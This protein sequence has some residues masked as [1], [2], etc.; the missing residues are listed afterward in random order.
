M[1]YIK[2]LLRELVESLLWGMGRKIWELELIVL[3][4]LLELMILVL[5]SK[6]MNIPVL[7]LEVEEL[8]AYCYVGN[9]VERSF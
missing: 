5:S 6:R 1:P 7:T 8:Y 9:G 3:Y 4:L 2:F